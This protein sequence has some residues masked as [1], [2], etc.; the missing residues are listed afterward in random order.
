[1]SGITRTARLRLGLLVLVAAT[2]G[3]VAV[4]AHAASNQQAIQRT[5]YGTAAPENAPGQDLYL[6][7][8]VIAPGAKLA[9]HFHQGTQLATVRAGVLT[10]NVVSGTAVVTRANGTLKTFVGPAVVRLRRGDSLVENQSLVHYG[11]NRGKR[12]VVIELAALLSHGA[13]LAT[14]VGQGTV[15]ATSMRLETRLSSQA[16]TLHQVGA[17]GAV[18]YGWN[19]LTGTATLD[20]QAVGVEML[21]NVA[22]QNGS[23]PFFGF[24][25]LTFADGSTIALEMQGV[26][27]ADTAADTTAFSA[28]LIVLGGTGRYVATT[29]TGVFTGSRTAALGNDVGATFALQLHA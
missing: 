3:I 1:M 29:G 11:S 17:A 27:R 25:T 13:P 5:V 28:T 22:Y 8:V 4:A 10:Y 9:E 2:G 16:R 6:Q 15:D 24:V 20:A 19:R 26:A 18:T 7:K 21:G 23:G 14:P 12:P